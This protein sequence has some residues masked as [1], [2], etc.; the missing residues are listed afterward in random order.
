MTAMPGGVPL[1]EDWGHWAARQ[2]AEAAEAWLTD[3]RDVGAYSRL[4][5]ATIEWRAY[6]YPSASASVRRPAGSDV[7]VTVTD[8]DNDDAPPLEGKGHPQR[9]GKIVDFTDPQSALAQLNGSGSHSE[10]GGS[11]GKV[12]S[13]GNDGGATTPEAAER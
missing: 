1:G 10:S 4:V 12:G 3:P 11:G 8:P 2:V 13:N 5:Q 6:A 9:L 7:A